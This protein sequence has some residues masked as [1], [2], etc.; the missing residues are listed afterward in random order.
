MNSNAQT[1]KR[2]RAIAIVLT[3]VAGTS[4]A[5]AQQPESSP[6]PSLV[7][8]VTDRLPLPLPLPRTFERREDSQP[9]QQ[10]VR[11]TI[12][13]E[14]KEGYAEIAVPARH[15]LVIEH[16]SALMQGPSGQRYFASLRTTVR[17]EETAWH[18]LVLSPQYSGAGIDVYAAAQPMRVYADPDGLPMRFSVSRGMDDGGTVS[19][20][21]T[22][23]G[24][25]LDR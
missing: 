24:Y 17:R 10:T 8:A 19:V 14:E 5:P 18:Y 15:R 3:V 1:T 6:A 20:D 9:F 25:L 12:G 2:L 7:P 22:V 23:S 11:F 13:N 16:V 21:A 4:A